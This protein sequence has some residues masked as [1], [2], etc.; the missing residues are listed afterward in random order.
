MPL[1]CAASRWYAL[2]ISDVMRPKDGRSSGLKA[3]ARRAI[4][5]TTPG[6][7]PQTR[8]WHHRMSHDTTQLNFMNV[9][10]DMAY[11]P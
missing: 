4:A 7:M 6:D 1:T 8:H 9:W 10:L 3:S 5:Y 11:A 2:F